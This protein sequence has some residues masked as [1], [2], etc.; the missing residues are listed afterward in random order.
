M[1]ITAACRQQLN[2]IVRDENLHTLYDAIVRLCVD[3]DN[4]AV[5][6]E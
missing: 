2:S 6:F 3:V 1:L 4:V 5:E